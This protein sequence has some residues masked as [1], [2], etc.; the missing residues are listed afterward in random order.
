MAI[1]VVS[2]TEFEIA[3]FMQQAKTDILITG[4]GTAATVYHLTR[5]LHEKQ[6]D[7]VIQ[8]GIAGAFNPAFNLGEVVFIKKDTFADS[9]IE[10]EG[11]FKTLFET[12]FSGKNDFPYTDGWLVNEHFL[13]AGV[14]LPAASGITVETV[15]GNSSRNE[16][17]KRLFSTGTESMEGAAFHYVC[18]QQHVRFLQ[19]RSI[20]N[21]TGER[22]KT[23][24]DIR[25]AVASLHKELSRIV[26]ENV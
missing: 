24:W 12:G 4:L 22:D 13:A 16:I 11:K 18:L 1:L 8:A 10:E 19:I 23:K 6:Y 17:R 25:K 9:G 5:R 15:T 14:Q 21:Y 2:A 7:L 20:S 3:P 26:N